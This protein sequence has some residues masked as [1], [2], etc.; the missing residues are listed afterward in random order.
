MSLNWTAYGNEARVS[1]AGSDCFRG[2][3]LFDALRTGMGMGDRG[4]GGWNVCFVGFNK[5]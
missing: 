2:L 4:V 1:Y 5:G 3:V